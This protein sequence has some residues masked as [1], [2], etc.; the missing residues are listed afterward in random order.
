M[1]HGARLHNAVP[2]HGFDERGAQAA[3][4]AAIAQAQAP[5]LAAAP[6]KHLCAPTHAV[7]SGF[8]VVTKTLSGQVYMKL[9]YSCGPHSAA[10]PP[11]AT[12]EQT[13]MAL[14]KLLSA[15]GLMSK[16]IDEDSMFTACLCTACTMPIQSVRQIST[17]NV[18][19]CN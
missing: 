1:D 5:I 19:V 3:A 17:Y 6:H 12:H 13:I 9:L 10:P 16:E 8:R 15:Q 2:L 11:H 18:R 7:R 4:A 14:R